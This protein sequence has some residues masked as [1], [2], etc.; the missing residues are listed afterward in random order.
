MTPD[1]RRSGP[2]PS[3]TDDPGGLPGDLGNG[4]S[5]RS[6]WYDESASGMTD[7]SLFPAN[8]GGRTEP[9]GSDALSDTGTTF[10]TGGDDRGP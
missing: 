5:E 10:G 8:P 6:G 3:E 9:P 2:A 7:T 1:D 4:M